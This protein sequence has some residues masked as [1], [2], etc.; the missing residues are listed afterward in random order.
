VRTKCGVPTLLAPAK[1][2]TTLEILAR[3]DDGYHTLRSVMVPI[4]L[5]DRIDLVPSDAPAFSASDPALSQGNLVVRALELARASGRYAATLHKIIPV[6]GG[7]GGGSSDAA[8]IL[9]AAMEGELGEVASIDWLDAARTLGSDVPFFLAG[10]GALV[11]G[12][13]ERVTAI[14]TVPDWWVV[15]V[16]PHA[17]DRTADAYRHHDGAR[18]ALPAGLPSRPRATS[19]SLA[20]I[21]ALQRR[22]FEAFAATLVNDFHDVILAAYPPVAD[23]DRALRAAGAAHVLLSGSGSCLFAPFETENDARATAARVDARATD[24]IFTVPFHH[25]RA[26]R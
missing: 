12:T 3:R 17:F 19:V 14:G 11:E 9:R 16:R 20:A 25:D 26:W 15:V 7:L 24:A 8:A 18:A 1:I 2:N 6:G 23:A 21:D 4:A 13:G 10:T 5:Y 22:D